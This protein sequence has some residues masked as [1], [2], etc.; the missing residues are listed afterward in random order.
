MEHVHVVVATDDLYAQH[1]GVMFVS[2]LENKQ[3]NYPLTLHVI[4][5]GISAEN[6]AR[7]QLIARQYA[8][9][10]QMITPDISRYADLIS[11]VSYVSHATFYRLSITEFLDTHIEKAIYLDC[12]VIIKQDIYPLWATDISTHSIAAVKDYQIEN[13]KRKSPVN[14]YKD[15]LGIPESGTYFNAGVLLINLHKWREEQF[16][17]QLLAYIQEHGAALPF[18]DQDA[19]NAFFHDDC[20]FLPACWNQQPQVYRLPYYR[21]DKQCIAKPAIIHYIGRRKPWSAACTHPLRHVYL[22]YLAL[23]PW[24]NFRAPDQSFANA[25]LRMNGHALNM[26]RYL[27]YRSPLSHLF[28]TEPEQ[29]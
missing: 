8:V 29:E 13:P 4:D 9:E 3:G 26:L 19:L 7:L 1:V 5:G 2:M 10:L 15:Q 11:S 24:K 23:S 12:D 18:S 27:H 21:T 16:G 25:L 17:Q 6:I 14:P 20:Y 28:L 22:R